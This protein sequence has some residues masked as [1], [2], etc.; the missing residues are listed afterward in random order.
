MA[1]EEFLDLTPLPSTRAAVYAA[2]EAARGDYEQ[3]GINVGDLGHECDRKLWYDLRRVSPLEKTKGQMLRLFETGNIEEKRIIDD[4]VDAGCE[5]RG[6]QERVYFVGAHVR[7]K[8]DGEVLG[9][10]EAPDVIHLLECKSSNDRNFKYLRKHG[11]QKAQPKHYAQMQMY[12]HGRSLFS[13]YYHVVNKNDEDL[14]TELIAYDATYCLLALARAERIVISDD[15]PSRCSNKP[16]VP[17]CLFCRH[18][19]VCHE[20]DWPRRNCRTCLHATA[21]TSTENASWNCA[22][23]NKPLTL[24]EQEA[25]CD[26]HLYLPEIVPG[27]QVDADEEAE[28]VTYELRDGSTWVNGNAA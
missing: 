3:R 14:H 5:I 11:V 28:T 27:V 16:R 25:G 26:S 13:A 21:V 6:A 9:V 2:Y 8:I 23:W 20:G 19:G 12:M 10:K 1:D 22:R 17:P 24:E 18:K 7:G 4:L 15:P